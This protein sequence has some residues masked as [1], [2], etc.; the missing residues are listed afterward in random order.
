MLESDL[1]LKP[2]FH[3]I[4]TIAVIAEKKK[5]HHAGRLPHPD[6]ISSKVVSNNFF[7]MESFCH[8]NKYFKTETLVIGL[9]FR[10]K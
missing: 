3:M 4:A 1:F 5:V 2:G 10:W 9:N 7:A 6:N 8:I